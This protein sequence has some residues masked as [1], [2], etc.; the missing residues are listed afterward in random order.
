MLNHS[1]MVYVGWPIHRTGLLALAHRS[2]ARNSPD[3]LGAFAAHGY[4][5]SL[6]TVV[7]TAPSREL[8]DMY[9]AAVGVILTL[10]MMGRLPEVRTKTGTGEAIRARPGLQARRRTAAVDMF[11]ARDLWPYPVWVYGV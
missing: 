9:Y 4:K 8:Q 10:E 11:P 6:V 5:P 3:H 2:A 1:V 7:A